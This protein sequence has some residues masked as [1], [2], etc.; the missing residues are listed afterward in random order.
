[1]TEGQYRVG[2][3]FNPG[4]NPVVGELKRVSA[5]LIDLIFAIP[6]ANGREDEI[7]RLQNIAVQLIED[8]AMW[9]VKAATKPAR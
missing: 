3:D 6:Q 9:A 4:K 7:T 2:I 5:N 1:M 8:G